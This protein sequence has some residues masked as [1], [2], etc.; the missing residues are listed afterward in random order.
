MNTDPTPRGTMLVPLI[1]ACAL[2]ME[3]LDATVVATAL[4]DIARS[5]GEDPLQLSAAM[6]SYMLSLAVFLPVSGWAADRFGARRVFGSAIV[7]FTLGSVLCGL[8]QDLTALVA[9]RMVQGLGGALMV[10]VGRLV[11]LRS[12]PR[13]RLVRA[14]STVTMPALVGPAIGPLVGGFITTYVSWR[15]IFFINV[16]I[17]LL[18]FALARAYVPDVREADPGPLD[19][20]GLA[21]SGAGLAGLIFGFENVGRGVVAPEAV[22]GVL[23]AAALCVAL[24]VWRVRGRTRPVLDPSLLRIPTYAAAVTGGTLF[25]MGIGAV[26][27]LLPMLFQVGFGMT[28]FESGSLTFAS[29]AGALTMKALAGPILRRVGFRRLLIGNAVLSGA[30]LA[31]YGLF[32]PDTPHA[33]ILAALL[34]GGFFRSL[35]FTGMNTLA[36]ADMPDD[37]MSGA[38]TLS[39]VMQQVSLSL[40]VA[41]GALI[42]HLMQLRHPGIASTPDDFGA[43]FAAGGVLATSAALFFLPL[44]AEAGEEVSGHR[45]CDRQRV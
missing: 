13:A 24:Y 4:P 43:A 2:F 31:G 25:R 33:V 19:L 12:V 41:T 36:Y 5:L 44:P 20:P 10:P 30:I 18:G 28:P 15:W 7:V 3:N 37:R 11:V 32:R 22:A 26:P 27:F 9:A 8:A 16:P 35:Q 21:L 14:M 17:G 6:T 38:N 42:L 45:R 40:G 1:V 34:L 29:A 39:S 23:A